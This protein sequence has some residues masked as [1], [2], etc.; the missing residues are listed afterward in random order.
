V[1]APDASDDAVGDAPL[2]FVVGAYEGAQARRRRIESRLLTRIPADVAHRSAPR[3]LARCRR[4]ESVCDLPALE[5]MYRDCWAEER[6]LRREAVALV[7]AHATW[8]WLARV[9]GMGPVLAARLLARLRLERAPTP[10]S[11]AGYCGLTSVRAGRYGCDVCGAERHAALGSPPPRHRRPADGAWCRASLVLRARDGRV[12]RAPLLAARGPAF[13]RRA[14]A[15]VHLVGA[16]LVRRP[17]VYQ[18]FYEARVQRRAGTHAHWPARRRELAALRATEQL[19]LLHLWQTWR[20]ARGLPVAG[21]YAEA[22]LGLRRLP[23]PDVV[24]DPPG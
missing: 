1:S 3:A 19:F 15:V 12:A 23:G 2:R 7:S 8:P 14:R 24:V 9:P 22:R 16:S 17:G 20:A 11:F 21:A 18:A 13:D 5:T 6:A 10:S 4:G